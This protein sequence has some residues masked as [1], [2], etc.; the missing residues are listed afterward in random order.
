MDPRN[1]D[2]VRDI[3]T[4]I[5]RFLDAYTDD[6]VPLAQLSSEIGSA[7]DVL[8]RLDAPSRGEMMSEFLVIDISL[9]V[10]FD[11]GLDG[12]R[13]RAIDNDHVNLA[14]TRLRALAEKALT[15]NPETLFICSL[16]RE[17]T[18]DDYL[19]LL[20][21]GCSECAYFVLIERSWHETRP[22]IFEELAQDVVETTESVR[23]P[24][25]QIFD[26]ETANVWKIATSP[27]SKDVLAAAADSLWDWT[28]P[29]LPEDLSFLRED[30]R[31]YF[32]S[33]THE[34]EAWFELNAHELT[35]LREVFYDDEIHVEDSDETPD[36]RE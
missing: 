2:E 28:G 27:R 10:A 18:R 32:I 15:E 36:E 9:S 6:S 7:M 8:E 1:T 35:L 30:G 23:W 14:V 17:W 4:G 11:E 26:R 19:T 33:V 20:A 5:I 29:S 31:P 22:P 25:T 13:P 21:L 24:G 16:G 3:W 34:R 12:R